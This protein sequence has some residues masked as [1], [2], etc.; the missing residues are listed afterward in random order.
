MSLTRGTIRVD[1][2]RYTIVVDYDGANNPIYIG[3]AT[4]GSAKSA[5]LWQIRKLTF[6]GSNNCTDIQYANGNELFQ[7][8]WNNRASLGYS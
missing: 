3:L 5:A 6:D 4:Q 1:G 7:S 8:I 2:A